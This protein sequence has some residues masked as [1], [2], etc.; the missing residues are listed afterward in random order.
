M[1]WIQLGD[2]EEIYLEV[3]EDYAVGAKVALKAVQMEDTGGSGS[4]TIRST[5]FRD[6]LDGFVDLIARNSELHVSPR[7]QSA[8]IIGRERERNDRVGN[9]STLD[10]WRLAAPGAIVA[11][12]RTI[13][14]R[15]DL[16]ERVRNP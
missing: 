6:T 2:S 4:I 7:F 12:L 11:P 16:A 5:A 13:L 3:G 15:V 14:G 1:V 8:S 9:E 10:Y